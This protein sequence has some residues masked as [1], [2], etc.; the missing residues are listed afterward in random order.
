MVNS[1]YKLDAYV[2][3]TGASCVRLS[4]RNIAKGFFGATFIVQRYQ[5]YNVPRHK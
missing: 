5:R 2:G 4:A 1:A 3:L